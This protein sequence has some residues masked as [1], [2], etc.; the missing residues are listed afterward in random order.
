MTRK[1]FHG[2]KR[3]KFRMTWNKYN[4]YNLT[5]LKQQHVDQKTYFQ[6]KWAA[7]SAS[8][9]YHGE[10][11]REGQWQRM[12][13]SRLNAV[14]P[15][16]HRYLA[17]FDGSE[18][19]T[20]RGSGRELSDQ[21]KRAASLKPKHRTPYMQMTYAPIERRLDVAIFRALFA[22]S[23]RQARQFVTHGSVKVNGKKMPYPGYLLNP[24]DMFQVD[25][26]RVLFATGVPKTIEQVRR[27]RE[28][29]KARRIANARRNEK[30]K[31]IRE[32][33]LKAASAKI[34]AEKKAAST[35]SVSQIPN[36]SKRA[37]DDLETRKQR[38]IE[39]QGIIKIIDSMLTVGTNKKN[40]PKVEKL[41]PKRK[42]A[43]RTLKK[44]LR[45]GM[46]RCGTLPID[47]LEK[48]FDDLQSRF[49]AVVG[50]NIV[51]FLPE[52]IK[53][54]SEPKAEAE[55]GE[56]KA[57]AKKTYIQTE[58]KPD[59]HKIKKEA[60]EK[61]HKETRELIRQS[62]ENPIDESKPYATPWQPRPYMSAFAFIPRYLEVNHNICSAVYLR[63]P[64][65]RPS[66]AEVPTPFSPETMQLAFNWYLRRR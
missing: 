54:K 53:P 7:K 13:S 28:L 55:E 6:Q 1:R 15:M 58:E 26:E 18:Q 48:T 24:G 51:A 47:E 44:D 56:N 36:G 19:A 46:G 16:D 40:S 17:E 32:R 20:G 31:A 66:V 50:S 22:S 39:I 61:K 52:H 45:I 43:L 29:R 49:G 63:H 5:R 33:M 23:A 30:K 35:S 59:F 12:F 64:V 42:Q 4:L 41:R 27:G 11:I 57:E 62:R 60:K 25:P 8:R 38:K 34:A 3:V 9:A 65:A 21:E 10:Q 14:V 2:L 37:V